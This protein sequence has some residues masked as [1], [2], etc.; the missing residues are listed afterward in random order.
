MLEKWDVDEN[1]FETYTSLI[2]MNTDVDTDHR[3]QKQN[4]SKSSITKSFLKGKNVFKVATIPVS[5]SGSQSHPT[6]PKIPPNVYVVPKQEYNPPKIEPKSVQIE[7]AKIAPGQNG[8]NP[9]VI[10]PSGGKPATMAADWLNG[11]VSGNFHNINV[12]K[13]FEKIKSVTGKS[14]LTT[15]PNDSKV[16]L[17]KLLKIQKPDT[18]RSKRLKKSENTCVNCGT[19]TATL[20]RRI[21]SPQEI[22]LKRP[23]V[24][25]STDKLEY[26]GKLACNSCALYWSLH[27]VSFTINYCGV[28]LF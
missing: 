6:N 14:E 19:K 22:E 21:K 15:Y 3:N 16:Q 11:N 20:W 26:T 5:L 27:G 9:F 7:M 2:D 24:K 23:Y 4:L 28:P 1:D 25:A 10:S 13:T 12:A 8:T 17:E 18:N